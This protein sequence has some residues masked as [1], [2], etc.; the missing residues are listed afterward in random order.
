[1]NKGWRA[2]RLER[3]Q[4]EEGQEGRQRE[5]REKR[6]RGTRRGENGSRFRE[7]FLRGEM[8]EEGKV[9]GQNSWMV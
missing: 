6:K 7:E 5:T 4:G 8:V 1:M 2:E 9:K 3:Q